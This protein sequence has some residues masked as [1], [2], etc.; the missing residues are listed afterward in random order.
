[1]SVIPI[2]ASIRIDNHQHQGQGSGGL[3]KEVCVLDPCTAPGGQGDCQRS[4]GRSDCDTSSPGMGSAVTGGG[5]IKIPL[6]DTTPTDTT[7]SESLYFADTSGVINPRHES[8]IYGI[9]QRDTNAVLGEDESDEG[10][11]KPSNR[12]FNCGSPDHSV[13]AC[14]F[15]RNKELISLSRQYYN[16]YRELKGI[17]DHPRIYLA[18][19]WRQQRLEWLDTLQPGHIQNPLLQEAIGFGDGDW[20]KNIATWGYPP[21]W[22]SVRDPREEVRLRIWDEHL[23][24]GYECSGDSFH[25]FSDADEPEDVSENIL[26]RTECSSIDLTSSDAV[27]KPTRWAIYPSTYFSSD[28]LFAYSRQ[29]APPLSSIEWSA[30][31]DGEGD[32]SQFYS[33]PPPPPEDPPP[34]PPPPPLITPSLPSPPSK[35]SPNIVVAFSPIV[36]PLGCIGDEQDMDISDSE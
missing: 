17:I 2:T 15:R 25:I 29:E 10:D 36:T 34:I 7:P 27:Y 8:H 16:F 20:L 4:L 22:N 14:P 3:E 30:A 21:G 18:E 33:Q 31:F 12:C 1:M 6:T 11:D 35:F 24:N 26:S 13:F 32:F 28:L 5:R 19:G 9:Y 23:D